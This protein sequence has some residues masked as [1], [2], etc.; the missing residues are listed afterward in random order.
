[1]FCTVTAD[2]LLELC[3]LFPKTAMA[4]QQYCI[5]QIEHLSKTRA[6]KQHLHTHNT[7]SA[8]FGKNAK[9]F[10]RRAAAREELSIEVKLLR[11]E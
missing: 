3:E 1:M 10:E 4:L 8:E 9:F 2:Y 6:L 7:V 11:E 5:E